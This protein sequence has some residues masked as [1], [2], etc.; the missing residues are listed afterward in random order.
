[1]SGEALCKSQ[2]RRR[3]PISSIGLF[4]FN[5][6]SQLVTGHVDI[7]NSEDDLSRLNLTLKMQYRQPE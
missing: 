5:L 7:E 2:L 1:M 3:L 4:L 6:I